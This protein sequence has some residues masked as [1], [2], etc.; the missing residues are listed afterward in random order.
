MNKIIFIT[1]GTRSGKSRFAEQIAAGFGSQLCYLATAQSLDDEM[2]Q[3]IRTHQQRR[4][5]M[6]QTI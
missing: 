4:G 5:D 3:R 6:W 2:S 1:G